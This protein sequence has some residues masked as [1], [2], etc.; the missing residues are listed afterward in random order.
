V[1]LIKVK[2]IQSMYERDL[3]SEKGKDF[4]IYILKLYDLDDEIEKEHLTLWNS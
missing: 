1:I 4:F 3:L 2:D